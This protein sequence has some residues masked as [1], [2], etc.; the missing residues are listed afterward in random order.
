MHG[1]FQ[2]YLVEEGGTEPLPCL[3]HSVFIGNRFGS[4]DSC[5]GVEI[6]VI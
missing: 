2:V 5:H 3:L 6:L 1:N 4:V